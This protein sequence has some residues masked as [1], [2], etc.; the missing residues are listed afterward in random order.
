MQLPCI[1]TQLRPAEGLA[2][3]PGCGR[4][5]TRASLMIRTA[6]AAAA[7]PSSSS[8]RRRP[9]TS[10]G[11]SRCQNSSARPR[12]AADPSARS[13][14]RH[15]RS[16]GCSAGLRSHAADS[17][18]NSCSRTRVLRLV[19]SALSRTLSHTGP[20]TECPSH[21][22]HCNPPCL[23]SKAWLLALDS[24]RVLG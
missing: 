14:S 15:G 3:K 10:L 21:P 22:K 12:S 8:A 18:S 11:S 1:F 20:A 16:R 9:G 4:L 23:P 7:A 2:P 13:A 17:S 24:T 5:K 19:T 6:T